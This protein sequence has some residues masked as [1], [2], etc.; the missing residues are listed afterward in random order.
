MDEIRAIRYFNK[1]VET[2]SFTQAAIFFNVP[3][4]SISRSITKLETSLKATLLQRSTRSVK[5]TEIGQI[6][7]EQTQKILSDLQHSNEMVSHY[8]TVPMGELRISSMVT[9][10]ELYLLPQLNKLKQLYPDILLDVY[11]S[12]E[13][14][15]LNEDQVDIAI[16]GGQAPD[17]RIIATKLM[18]ND[19]FPISSPK[20]IA[21]YGMPKTASDLKQHRGLYFRTPQ[22]TTP[23]LCQL[24]DQWHNVSAPAVAIS[25]SYQWLMDKL[26]HGEGI[27]ML[28]L[29]SVQTHLDTGELCL[30]DLNPKITITTQ[31][32]F[33]VYM[34]Y[35]KQR[36]QVPKIKVAV[37]FLI[38][39]LKC[40]F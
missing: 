32:G 11:L 35:Q 24:N 12:D 8:Q 6:Y 7:Y 30:L 22:G 16:R 3:T 19:F 25:N 17:K 26:L 4:S 37:D 40:N 13:L 29:W 5:P 23:W 36:Y 2:G 31:Q 38:S 34:L 9:F 33:G 39:S 1:V 18:P 15:D 20:Y 10:G 28:P 27:A 21:R 14:S